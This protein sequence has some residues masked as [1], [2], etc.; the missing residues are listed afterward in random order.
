MRGSGQQRTGVGAPHFGSIKLTLVNR[1]QFLFFKRKLIRSREKPNAQGSR[2]ELRL[3]AVVG[4]VSG[5]A[6][7]RHFDRLSLREV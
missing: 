4:E 7:G 6:E 3:S 2:S 1:V 5:A